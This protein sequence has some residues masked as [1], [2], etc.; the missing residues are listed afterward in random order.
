MGFYAQID[1]LK[2]SKP[3][4]S[5]QELIETA[6]NSIK[7]ACAIWAHALSVYL[8]FHITL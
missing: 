7:K 8:A 4:R 3:N 5:E 1:T 6:G 2:K